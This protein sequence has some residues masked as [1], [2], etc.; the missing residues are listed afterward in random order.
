MFSQTCQRLRD[1][2]LPL[3]WRILES[4]YITEAGSPDGLEQYL[5]DHTEIAE[6][7][8]YV[9]LI[10]PHFICASHFKLNII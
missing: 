6:F 8:R 10:L 3:A 2:L 5:S 7:P 4:G 9:S 1:I